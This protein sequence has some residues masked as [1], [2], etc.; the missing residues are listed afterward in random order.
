MRCCVGI[1][2]GSYDFEASR[3][4][5]CIVLESIGDGVVTVRCCKCWKSEH[6]EQKRFESVRPFDKLARIHAIEICLQNG[7][8]RSV[9]FI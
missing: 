2:E 9:K 1:S 3:Q 7:K 4:G 5:A 8:N 6:T